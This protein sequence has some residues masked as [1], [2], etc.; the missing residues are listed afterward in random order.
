MGVVRM[1]GRGMLAAMMCWAG[2]ASAA[3]FDCAKA[4]GKMEQ[5]ICGEPQLSRLDE[6]LGAAYRAVVQQQD[7]HVWKASQLYWLK[8]RNAC[9]DAACATARYQ[10]R[11]AEFERRKA[12]GGKP[13]TWPQQI[14]GAGSAIC[15][16]AMRMALSRFASPL[17]TLYAPQP[18]P[19]R[20]G[21]TVALAPASLELFDGDG[22]ALDAQVFEKARSDGVSVIWQSRT[23]QGVRLA[24]VVRP[25]GWRGDMHS[26][27]LADPATSRDAFQRAVD[28]HTALPAREVLS[29]RW[30]P[31]LVLR[32]GAALWLLDMGEPYH[33]LHDW[34]I[35]A[36]G[37]DRLVPR[38]TIR[39]HPQVEKAA[40]LLPL[41][42]Q[43]L[44]TLLDRTMG[45]G[46]DEG[47]LQQ[48]ARLRLAVQQAWAN[49]AVRPWAMAEPR[50]SRQRVDQGLREWSEGDAASRKLYQDIV[51]QYPL[52]QQALAA[53]YEKTLQRPA[54]EAA[55]WAE[56]V[57]DIAYRAHY[58][59][60]Q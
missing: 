33:F 1:A 2:A 22:L 35:Y 23:E 18:M 3:S 14:G 58:V 21:S 15:G 59:M 31:P 51:Q 34:T 11:L 27:F 48:T 41:P 44:E 39:F 45:S 8:Q 49:A 7:E 40:S 28:Q 5:L 54:H 47:T 17:A 9:E 30:W 25:R 60:P 10:E 42:V 29:D 46:Q 13:E 55:Q 37:P 52:A 24:I 50:N 16:Q 19:D 56:R 20:L 12:A 26:Y 38:C 43:K 32:D 53:Y 36:L 6:Q 57:L 4:A